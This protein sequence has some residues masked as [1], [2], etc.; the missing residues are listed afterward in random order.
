M[1]VEAAIGLA[2]SQGAAAFTMR[3]LGAAL[4]VD[5]MALYRH[6][7]NKEELLDALADAVLADTIAPIGSDGDWRQ[8]ARSAAAG[9]RTALLAHP[10]IATLVARRPHG[11]DNTL[12]ATEAGMAALLE[13]G[14]SPREAA[15][16]FRTLTGFTLGYVLL[17]LGIRE[18]VGGP[19]EPVLRAR[20]EALD[21]SQFPAVTTCATELAVVEGDELFHHGLDLLLL[22]LERRLNPSRRKA[23]ARTGPSPPAVKG[24]RKPAR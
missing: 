11:G 8:R 18:R 22:G 6:F 4:G 23:P 9:Y 14:F 10:S 15:F 17:E 16:A 19:V 20:Y 12:H 3:A 2:E 24:R 1:I 13:A 21:T 7:K 5:P